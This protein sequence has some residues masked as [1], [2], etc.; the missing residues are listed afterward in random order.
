MIFIL[1]GAILLINLFKKKLSQE[2]E[3][4]SLILSKG[5]VDSYILND[6]I[7]FIGAC[8]FNKKYLE[9]IKDLNKKVNV[10]GFGFL[11]FEKDCNDELIFDTI[12]SISK[13]SKIKANENIINYYNTH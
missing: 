6:N 5:S 3:N 2:N 8:S 7:W 12:E 9:R 13:K 11:F 4:I 10:K 1:I